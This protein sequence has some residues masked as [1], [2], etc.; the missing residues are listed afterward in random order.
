MKLTRRRFFAFLAGLPLIGLLSGISLRLAGKTLEPTPACDDHDEPTPPQT[1]GPYFTPN[2]P[3]RSNLREKGLK[4][5]VLVLTGQVL[6]TDCKPVSRA[7]LDW[8]HC[9]DAGHYDNE[10]FTLR[11]HH[12]TDKLG[13]FRLETIVPGL[14][15]GRTRHLHVKVQAPGKPIL[16]T[17]L[18]FPDEPGN[19]RDGIF[20]PV[21]V[22]DVKQTASQMQAGYTFVLKA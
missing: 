3:E 12:F 17:Q 8:W 9:D 14:Y 19:R 6:N 16:T 7:L 10:G 21:L 22:M 15:P 11:G 18:Y 4:G 13:N 20:K 1:E 2:S 5:T